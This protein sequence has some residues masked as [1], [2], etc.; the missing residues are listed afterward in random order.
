[1]LY[2]AAKA[3]G[4]LASSSLIF[5]CPI[6]ACQPSE[7]PPVWEDGPTFLIVGNAAAQ[8]ASAAAGTNLYVQARGGDYVGIVVHGGTHKVANMPES[9]ASSC[10]LLPGSGPLYF[11]VTPEASDCVIEVR[12]YHLCDGASVGG[13]IV[14][15]EIC[16]T[17]GTF[18][19]SSNVDVRNGVVAPR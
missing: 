18:I 12:L 6:L 10:A 14:P 16:D 19:T 15:L 13:D 17:E 8:P 11:A 4:L 5:A 9:A 7:T 3:S 1:M 2:R